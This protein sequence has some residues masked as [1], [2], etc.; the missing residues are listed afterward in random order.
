M[1]PWPAVALALTIPAALPPLAGCN[2]RQQLITGEP[3]IYAVNTPTGA[4]VDRDVLPDS[5][6]EGAPARI[7]PHKGEIISI[8]LNNVFIRHLEESVIA[9][10]HVLVYAEVYDGALDSPEAAFSKVLYNAPN[11][12]ENVNLGLSDRLIYGPTPYK[13]FPIRI[14]FFIVELDKEQKETAAK[15]ITAAGTL[16]S[17]LRPEAAPIVGIAVE[18]AQAINA[19]NEDD[20]ELRFDMTLYPV[21]KAGNARTGDPF[22]DTPSAPEPIQRQGKSFTLV[23]SLRTGPYIILKRELRSRVGRQAG[24][25]NAVNPSAV[26]FDWTQEYLTSSYQSADPSITAIE[27]EEVVRLQGGYLYRIIRRLLAHSTDAQGNPQT[28]EVTAATVIPRTGPNAGQPTSLSRG[29]K[30]SFADQ[31]Y[32][33]FTVLNGLPTGLDDAAMRADSAKAREQLA[34]LLDNPDQRSST[35]RIR[36]SIERVT[37]AAA[38]ALEQRRIAEEASRRVARQPDLRAKPE[39]PLLWSSQIEAADLQNADEFRKRLASGKNAAILEALADMVWNLPLL[40]PDNFKQM[41]AL[42]ALAPTDLAPIKDRPGAFTLSDTA[43][44]TLR[45]AQQN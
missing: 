13:G 34:T 16:A 12:P 23:N 9:N 1:R 14:R 6:P 3:L 8:V 26:Q 20:F 4:I 44:T 35:E 22:L 29:I 5:E 33:V 24:T 7:V 40:S 31:T 28:S 17:S 18:I 25:P 30:Q 39:Y 37:G 15:I 27:A 41:N 11:Q 32:S 19:L 21:D 38:T 42:R 43:M 45:N 2:P 36:E 10:P